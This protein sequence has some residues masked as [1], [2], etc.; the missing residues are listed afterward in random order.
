[1]A[2]LV[3]AYPLI[4]SRLVFDPCGG[5]GRV[6]DRWET[7]NSRFKIRI[8]EYEEKQP[9]ALHRFNYVFETSP[10]ATNNWRE[11]I[12]TWTDDD[13]RIPHD[14]VNFLTDAAGYVVMGEAVAV[15]SDGGQ[16]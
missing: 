14:S 8:T 3:Y 1:M 15:T 11:L 16:T 13:I 9:V 2:L 4:V 7:H 6:M 5:R 12:D 10:V